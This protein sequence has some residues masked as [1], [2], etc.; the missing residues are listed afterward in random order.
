M[1]L[2]WTEQEIELLEDA[3]RLYGSDKNWEKIAAHVGSRNA[4]QCAIK[5]RNQEW[6]RGKKWNQDVTKVLKELINQGLFFNDIR[7]RMPEYTYIQIY[8]QY[9][10]LTRNR[11]SL[12]RSYSVN[13][14]ER[15]KNAHLCQTL[16]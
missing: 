7:E 4:I 14:L 2:R 15:I 3:V 12:G 1:I 16:F 10:M 6:K 11:R 5:W 9:T 13:S 8:L